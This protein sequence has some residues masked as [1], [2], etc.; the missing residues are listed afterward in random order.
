[1]ENDDT[2]KDDIVRDNSIEDESHPAPFPSHP[3]QEL[4]DADLIRMVRDVSDSLCNL[5]I[6]KG[7][8]FRGPVKKFVDR[9][10]SLSEGRLASALSSFGTDYEIGGGATLFPKSLRKGKLI[11]VQPTACRRRKYPGSSCK[12]PQTPGRRPADYKDTAKQEDSVSSLSFPAP[13]RKK[14]AHSLSK[15]VRENTPSSKKHEANMK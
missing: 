9:F 8:S 13:K 2:S 10:N 14:R 5:I 3:G 4:N 12:R 11:P 6:N 15:A 7:D 1:M